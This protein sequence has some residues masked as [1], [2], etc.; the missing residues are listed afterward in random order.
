VFAALVVG[1]GARTTI[2]IGGPIC[3]CWRVGRKA[4]AVLARQMAAAHLEGGE[5][6]KLRFDRLQLTDAGDGRTGPILTGCSKATS[7]PSLAT[8]GRMAARGRLADWWTG[9]RSPE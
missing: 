3:W 9:S 5:K 6:G 8:G 2:P 1:S 4:I 7:A